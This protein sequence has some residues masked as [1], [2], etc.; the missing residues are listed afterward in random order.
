MFVPVKVT[1]FVIEPN[2]GPE[3]VTVIVPEVPIGI[4]YPPDVE[5]TA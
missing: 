3:A 2:P 1:V 5:V 4:A